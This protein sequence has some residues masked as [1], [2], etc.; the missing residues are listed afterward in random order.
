M[1]FDYIFKYI[2]IGDQGVGKTCLL[3]QFTE[4][5]F[6]PDA[7]H[8][9]G[10]EFGTRVCK[11]MEKTIK[12]Q[13]WD[14][15]GQERFR[16]VTRSYYRGAAGAL[17][18][19]DVTRRSTFNTLTNWL[20]DARSLATQN[21]VIML[22]GNKLDMESHREVSYDEAKRF[23]DDNALIYLEA[24]AKTGQNVEEAFLRTARVIY[25]N[26]QSGQLDL[27][28]SGTQFS[29]PSLTPKDGDEPKAGCNC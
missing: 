4:K 10:V 7:Q 9:V 23:A 27:T 12:L 18:V 29:R 11:V 3:H 16:A 25:D 28:D 22:I 8:T 24:S 5:K 26:I 21:T 13:I 2:V 1:S 14:T 19:F 15:A 20:A 6:I 17:L